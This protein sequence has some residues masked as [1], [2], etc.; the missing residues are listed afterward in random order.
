MTSGV[1]SRIVA[2]SETSLVFFFYIWQRDIVP[3]NRESIKIL[4]DIDPE[5]TKT[6]LL[7]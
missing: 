2:P 5:A 6:N 7:Q 1:K 3:P 4:V